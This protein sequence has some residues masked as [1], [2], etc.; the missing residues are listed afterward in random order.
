MYKTVLLEAYKVGTR[1]QARQRPT[2]PSK[3]PQNTSNT[4]PIES[5]TAMSYPLAEVTLPPLPVVLRLSD[6][7]SMK[8]ASFA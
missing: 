8:I 3:A 6:V 5:V 4:V 1:I 7:I 2:E